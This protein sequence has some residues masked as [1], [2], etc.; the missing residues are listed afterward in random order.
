MNPVKSDTPV[1]RASLFRSLFFS[2]YV[3]S[4]LFAFGQGLLIPV[5]PLYVK[6]FNIGY[7]L[8]GLVLAG[9]G[10]GMLVADIPAGAVLRKLN[11]KYSMILA[12]IGIA[13][14]NLLLFWANT[15]LMVFVLRVASGIFG[16]L[17][18]ISRHTH[19][20][21]AVSPERRGRAISV[22]GGIMRI[23]TFAGPVVGGFVASLAG[24][25]VPFLVFAAI[26]A[27]NGVLLVFFLGKDDI[28]IRGKSTGQPAGA[29]EG[30]ILS[31][32]VLQVIRLFYRRFLTAGTG[33]L[34]AQMI[35]SARRIIIPLFAAEALG[36][37]AQSIGTIL[38]ISAAVD[39]TLFYPAGWI[40][41]NFGRKYAVVTSILGL[42]IGTA[43]IPFT[44]GYTGLLLVG[45]FIGFSNGIGSGTMITLGAD[46]APPEAREE[47][48]SIWQLIGDAG[49]AGA[50]LVVGWVADL[51][52][53]SS[54]PWVIAGIGLAG[55]L[56]FAFGVRETLVK[57]QPQFT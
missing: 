28:R 55:A 42:V 19:L 27:L 13:L 17:W 39:M 18:H 26:A 6:S 15:I 3:P 14:A 10:F 5:L 50:P 47:F 40:M 8:I 22:F 33:Q 9:E 44:G 45:L 36:L 30:V 23:G 21:H 52:A 11:T 57:E 34:F 41:D 54:S 7:G 35:R 29:A 43:L 46:L 48:I 51:F 25:R 1:R 38:S 53:L 32:T 37:N 56:M 12:V 31:S 49:Q 2:V 16:S 20:V 4:L 24:M